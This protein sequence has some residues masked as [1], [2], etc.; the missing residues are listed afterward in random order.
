MMFPS[1]TRRR[2]FRC[3]RN[4]PQRSSG[5]NDTMPGTLSAVSVRSF[6]PQLGSPSNENFASALLTPSARA[7]RAAAAAPAHRAGWRGA[8]AVA[9]ASRLPLFAAIE[10]IALA[11]DRREPV[12]VLRAQAELG[13][14][15]RD[16]GVHRARRDVD[17][18]LPDH[19]EDVRARQRPAQMLEQKQR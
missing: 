13:A 18:L 11:V 5:A 19:V 3:S 6:P 4:E 12:A 9:P 2:G 7:A 17:G 14:Q 15:H 1:D 8:A 10:A 16:V